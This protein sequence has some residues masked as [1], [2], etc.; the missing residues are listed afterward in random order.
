MLHTATRCEGW[1][2]RQRRRALHTARTRVG[3]AFRAR[4]I[5]HI[6]KQRREIG[7]SCRK[8]PRA[9]RRAEVRIRAETAATAGGFS[10]EAKDARSGHTACDGSPG[11]SLRSAEKSMVKGVRETTTSA[12]SFSIVLAAL[13]SFDPRVRVRFASLFDDPGSTVLTP[14]GDRLS[15]LGSAVWLAARDQSIENAPFLVFGVVSVL[16]VVFMLRS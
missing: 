13:V 9:T 8:A 7:G 6:R 3:T 4:E 2:S 14:F 10:A 15:D 16:L 1:T 12:L 11:R 5:D